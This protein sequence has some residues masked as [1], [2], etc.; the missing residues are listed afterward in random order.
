LDES[1]LFTHLKAYQNDQLTNFGNLN[2]P[3]DS[4]FNYINELDN[5]FITN[6]PTLVIEDNVLMKLKNLMDNVPFTHP[7]SNFKLDFLNSLYL[8]LRIFHAIKKI[9]RDLLSAPREHSKL[10]ILYHL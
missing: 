3:L 1:F 10:D 7:C 6:F 2:V 4:F 8:R 9:N 5:I